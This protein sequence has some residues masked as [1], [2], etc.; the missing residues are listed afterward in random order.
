VWIP[1]RYLLTFVP[2]VT[3]VR[4]FFESAITDRVELEAIERAGLR[5][6]IFT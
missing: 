1:L 3:P 5:Q 6:S 2:V 4:Q